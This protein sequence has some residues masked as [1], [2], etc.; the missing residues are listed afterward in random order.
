LLV[1]GLLRSLQRNTGE[2]HSNSRRSGRIQIL[3]GEVGVNLAAEQLSADVMD[4][5]C[6][7]R[8][9]VGALKLVKIQVSLR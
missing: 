3:N 4:L 9:L 6:A 7:I 2:G 1:N 5:Q 8:E